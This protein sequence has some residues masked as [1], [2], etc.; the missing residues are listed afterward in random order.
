MG[1]RATLRGPV[2]RSNR[3]PMFSRQLLAASARSGL[4]NSTCMSFSASAKVAG[5]TSGPAAC[6]VPNA[7]GAP[8][9]GSAVFGDLPRHPAAA[10]IRASDAWVRNCLRDFDIFPMSSGRIVAMAG[11]GNEPFLLEVP[12]QGRERS[13]GGTEAQRHR[14]A[15]AGKQGGRRIPQHGRSEQ[16]PY[17]GPVAAARTS[18]A[19]RG[20]VVLTAVLL[21]LADVF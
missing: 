21:S 5:D 9:G 13:H 6:D 7:G 18:K 17:T 14:G 10:P 12:E 16:R 8:G 3:E 4:V 19:I 2:R 20:C 11:T 15:E 1:P